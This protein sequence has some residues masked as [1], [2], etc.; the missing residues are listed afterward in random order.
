MVMEMPSQKGS[1]FILRLQPNAQQQVEQTLNSDMFPTEDIQSAVAVIDTKTG[2]IAAV[3]GG[4][5]YGAD[6]GFNFAKI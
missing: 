2:A 5:N 4:R 1:Q 6:R 3:G